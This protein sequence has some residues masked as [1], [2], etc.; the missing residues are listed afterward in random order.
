M[1]TTLQAENIIK[2]QLEKAHPYLPD[3]KLDINIIFES[4]GEGTF[5]NVD[6]PCISK[7]N[8][9]IVNMDWLNMTSLTSLDL[10]YAIWRE[11]R[12]LYQRQ[13]VEA[14]QKGTPVQESLLTLEKW[15]SEHNSYIPNTTITEKRHFAQEIVLDAYSFSFALLA[16]FCPKSDG[17]IDV[18]LPPAI[19]EQVA[20]KASEMYQEYVKVPVMKDKVDRNGECP[21]GSGKKYKKCC[22][23]TGFFE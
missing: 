18:A 4:L 13:Q 17:S 5:K 19:A 21:C 9:L 16:I 3:F 2:K 22:I 8:T 7:E 6:T 12:Y 23:R 10:K 20:E 1:Y 11:M 15:E 14:F